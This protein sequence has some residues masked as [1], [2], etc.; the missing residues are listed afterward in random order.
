MVLQIV[1]LLKS[2]CLKFTGNR[3]K[4]GTLLGNVVHLLRETNAP[5]VS[6]IACIPKSSPGLE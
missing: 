3:R 1:M 5:G 4:F 6:R 2:H